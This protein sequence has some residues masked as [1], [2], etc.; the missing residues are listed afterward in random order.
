MDNTIVITLISE[1]ITLVGVIV[2]CYFSHSKTIYRIDQLE[3][4]QEKYNNLIAR[5]YECE[6]QIGIL[7]QEIEHQAS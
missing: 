6:K 1:V 5:T 2:T 4:K 7:Q 3:K